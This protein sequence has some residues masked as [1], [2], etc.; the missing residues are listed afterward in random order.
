MNKVEEPRP[1]RVEEPCPLRIEE[2]PRHQRVEEPRPK[3]ME[4]PRPLLDEPLEK[5]KEHIKS[6]CGHQGL[7]IRSI[8]GRIQPIRISKTGFGSYR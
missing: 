7:R 5:P 2:P 6:K 1:Q 3:R 8:F 4:E